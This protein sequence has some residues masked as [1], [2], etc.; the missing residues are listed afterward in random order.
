MT[1]TAAI[2]FSYHQKRGTPFFLNKEKKRKENIIL[3]EAKAAACNG[4]ETDNGSRSSPV[5]EQ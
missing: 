2:S 3:V 5:L 4:E 1:Q